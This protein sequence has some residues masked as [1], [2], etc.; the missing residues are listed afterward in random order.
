MFLPDVNL[1]LA[2][3]F[4]AH[5]H[6]ESAA[7]WFDA[8]TD[9][10]CFFCRMTQQG[11]LRP[12][13]NPKVFGDDAVTLSEAWGIYDTLTSDPRVAYAE[14]PLQLESKW[15]GHTE[16]DTFSPKVWNDAYLAA[17]AE[18]GA[19]EVVTFDKGFAQYSGMQSTILT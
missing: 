1:W 5:A 3:A 12:A 8:A 6:H 19:L 13:T 9:G 16:R 10:S 7:N 11:L 18:S 17:F 4:E 2:L 15:R 14:E